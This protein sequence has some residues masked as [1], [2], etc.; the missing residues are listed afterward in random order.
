MQINSI[1][2]ATKG[3]PVTNT[4]PRIHCESCKKPLKLII[5]TQDDKLPTVI[6]TSCIQ[7]LEYLNFQTGFREEAEPNGYE[8]YHMQS[9]NN[10][11]HRF[12][13]D[14]MHSFIDTEPTPFDINRFRIRSE[15]RRERGQREKE[16]LDIALD[17]CYGRITRKEG[18][19]L[20]QPLYNN[21]DY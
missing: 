8:M 2:S 13:Q 18:I 9:Y 21:G 12:V 7:L 17:M 5:T 4:P 19:E 6:C 1:A 10:S 3:R 16:I 15:R 11:V 20:I 14:C